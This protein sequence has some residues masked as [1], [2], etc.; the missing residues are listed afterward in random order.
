MSYSFAKGRLARAALISPRFCKT[1]VV[2]LGMETAS[3]KVQRFPCERKLHPLLRAE[4]GKKNEH[5]R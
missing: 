4:P 5:S 3:A 2:Y 1:Q